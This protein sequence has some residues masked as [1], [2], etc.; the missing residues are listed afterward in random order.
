MVIHRKMADLMASF[1]SSKYQNM[2]LLI[3]RLSVQRG[4]PNTVEAAS[5]FLSTTS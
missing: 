1:F 2:L 5:F 3:L 4:G